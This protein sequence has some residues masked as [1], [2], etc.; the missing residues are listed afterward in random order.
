MGRVTQR[1]RAITC[2]GPCTSSYTQS[3]MAYMH[4]SVISL[5]KEYG[6]SAVCGR[7]QGE[8]SL[9]QVTRDGG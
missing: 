2:G 8:V 5:L 7:S 9:M 4:V 6:S 1:R 3:H